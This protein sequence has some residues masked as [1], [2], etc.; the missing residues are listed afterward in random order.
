[1]NSEDYLTNR[2]KILNMEVDVI[3]LKSAMNK[4]L[5]LASFDSGAYI[6]ASNVHMCIEAFSHPDFSKIVNNADL[7]LA[8]GK[9][10]YWA[11]KLLGNSSAKQ[12]RG[13]D[14]MNALCNLSSKKMLNIGLYGGSSEELI[15]EVES[16]LTAMFPGIKIEYTFSPP[17]RALTKEEDLKV[18]GEINSSDIDILFLGIGCPKQERWMAEHKDKLS[19]VMIGVGAAFDFLAGEKKQAP[20]WIQFIGF[21][22]MF[23]LLSEPRRLWK[24]YFTTI[25]LFL[26]HFSMQLLRYKIKKLR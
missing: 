21:E 5:E 14:I 10:I 13:Q 8:D 9:P 25:P 17:F 15:D 26:W 18:I 3:D 16:N 1:M 6:C 4:V 23:R 2:Q 11:Q 20:K 22:W 12:I 7:V 19:C 24:R